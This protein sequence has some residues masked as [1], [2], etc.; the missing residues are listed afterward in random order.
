MN[1]EAGW[2]ADPNDATG[3]RYWDG[4]AWTEHTHRPDAAPAA[5]FAPAAT[6]EPAVEA[7]PAA[8]F[9]PA[10]T[11]APTEPSAG[12]LAPQNAAYLPQTQ[13]GMGSYTEPKKG[14]GAGAII[15]ILAGCVVALATIA[16][17]VILVMNSSSPSTPEATGDPITPVGWETTTSPSGSIDFA[18]PTEMSDASAYADIDQ[19]EAQMSSTLATVMPG[20]TAEISGVWVDANNSDSSGSMLIVMSMSGNLGNLDLGAELMGFAQSASAG[21]SDFEAADPVDFTTAVGYDAAYLDSAASS[22]G[23]TV[24]STVSAVEGQDTAVFVYSISP[25]DAASASDLNRQVADSVV[26]NDVP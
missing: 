10:A 13:P 23:T 2:Y 1:P 16:V 22:Y 12:Y 3:L 26:I 15:G 24:Y 18:Y 7:A 20:V 11:F 8:A 17:I 14:L 6:F 4:T 21:S 5:A 9:A 25:V 19:L